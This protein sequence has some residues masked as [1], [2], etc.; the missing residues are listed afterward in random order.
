MGEKGIV[1]RDCF[2]LEPLFLLARDHHLG[3]R[4][5][6]GTTFSCSG[7]RGGGGPSAAGSGER[8]AGLKRETIA[9]NNPFLLHV[10]VHVFQGVKA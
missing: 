2:P 10:V 4:Q 7:Q 5:S 6:L 3:S 8:E 1:A 9:G